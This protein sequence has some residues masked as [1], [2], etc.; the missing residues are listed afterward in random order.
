MKKRYFCNWCFEVETP[1]PNSYCDEC[2]KAAEDENNKNID[3]DLENFLND[4]T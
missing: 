2:I 3:F 4:D 1:Q